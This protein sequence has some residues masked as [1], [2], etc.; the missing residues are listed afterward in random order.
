MRAEAASAHASPRRRRRWRRGLANFS[1]SWHSSARPGGSRHGWGSDQQPWREQA[2]PRNRQSTVQPS[3][4]PLRTGC[5]L[6]HSRR[7]LS[8]A[9]PCCSYCQISRA[10]PMRSSSISSVCAEPGPW[11]LPKNKNKPRGVE[12]GCSGP[13]EPRTSAG[14]DEER[15]VCAMSARPL[16]PHSR[17]LGRKPRY[18]RGKGPC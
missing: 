15:R 13:V 14:G 7:Y 18:G 9:P 2:R 12:G 17:T 10:V 5:L 4:D 11:P 3:S 8:G 1:L 6:K 16:L